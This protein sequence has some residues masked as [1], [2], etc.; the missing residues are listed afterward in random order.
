MKNKNNNYDIADGK[1]L[2]CGGNEVDELSRRCIR[3]DGASDSWAL[4][5]SIEIGGYVLIFTSFILFEKRAQAWTHEMTIL[6]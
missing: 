1:P 5:S 3:Y 4:N 2:L 6:Y